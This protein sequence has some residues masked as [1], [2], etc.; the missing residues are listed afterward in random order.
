MV[1]LWRETSP[2]IEKLW[3]VEAATPPGR[4]HGAQDLSMIGWMSALKL[5]TGV[6][7]VAGAVKEQAGS[8]APEDDPHAERA[9]SRRARLRRRTDLDVTVIVPV[10]PSLPPPAL[11]TSP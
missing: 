10:A 8:E 4:W 7:Q 2:Y 6:W 1:P 9:S 5:G 11:R 3:P